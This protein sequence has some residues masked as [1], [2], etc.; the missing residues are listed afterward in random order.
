MPASEKLRPLL[1]LLVLDVDQH[2]LDDVADLLHVD[3][4]ADDVGPAAAFFLGQRL[5]RDLGQVVLD[6]RI[7]LVDGVVHLAQFFGQL[8]VVVAG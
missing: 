8:E 2:A 1:D 3:G 6:R 7:E 4:E 5:A